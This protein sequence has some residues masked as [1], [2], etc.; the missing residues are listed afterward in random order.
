MIHY[1][2]LIRKPHVNHQYKENAKKNI[3]KQ[4][5]TSIQ[6]ESTNKTH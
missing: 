1:I 2:F 3:Q 5:S 6:L 4:T